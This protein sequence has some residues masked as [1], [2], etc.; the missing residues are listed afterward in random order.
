LRQ[1]RERV[2][3]CQQPATERNKLLHLYRR[4][5]MNS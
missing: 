5:E 3:P 4:R 2:L 1:F